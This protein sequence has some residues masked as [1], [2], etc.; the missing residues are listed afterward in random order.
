MAE[1]I[2]SGMAEA[3]RARSLAIYEQARAWAWARDLVLADS[4]FEFGLV[5]GALTLIDEALT[6]DSSRYWDRAAYEAGE[7]VGFDKQYVRDWLDASGWT[8]E[9][10][11]P[12][13]PD[14]VVAKTQARYLEAVRRLSGP[15]R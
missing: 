2:G 8:H 9:P 14:D 7:L 13:L 11:A 1:L 5:D 10:P 15:A 6:P 4:K 3:L 12:A